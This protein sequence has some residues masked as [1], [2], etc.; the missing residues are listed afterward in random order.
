MHNQWY[1]SSTI[2]DLHCRIFYIFSLVVCNRS[3]SGCSSMTSVGWNV[4]SPKWSHRQ[5]RV[6]YRVYYR[7]LSRLKPLENWNQ[8]KSPWKKWLV[9]LTIA[10]KCLI[11]HPLLI[12]LSYVLRHRKIFGWEP[13][14]QWKWLHICYWWLMFNS[15]WIS[16]Y[17]KKFN[18]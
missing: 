17:M 10:L 4:H 14:S 3:I 18:Y 2:S 8:R 6:W 9:C 15:S 12:W 5:W 16:V 1:Y 13:T 11:N 7:K